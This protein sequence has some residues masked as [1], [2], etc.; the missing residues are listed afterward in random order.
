MKNRL[1]IEKIILTTVITL[2][3]S[4][5]VSNNPPKENIIVYINNGAIQC[6]SKGQSKDQTAA[7][8]VKQGIK[9]KSSQCGHLTNIMVAAVCGMQDININTHQIA[10]NDLEKSRLLGFE[11]VTQLK[12]GNDIGYALANCQ[13]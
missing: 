7:L 12:Q 1:T 11:N 9:V 13:R 5:C 2:A 10:A 4:A 3:L 6:E 8:L